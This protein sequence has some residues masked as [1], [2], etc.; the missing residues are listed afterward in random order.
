MQARAA[1]SVP[2]RMDAGRRDELSRWAALMAASADAETARA[3]RVVQAL[4]EANAAGRAVERH[5]FMRLADQLAGAR[6]AELRSAGRAI[7]TLCAENAALDASTG[8]RRGLPARARLSKRGMLIAV[9]AF[10]TQCT[11][12]P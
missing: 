1:A 9:A 5:E 3:G 2:I 7:S 4:C 8:R 10:W 6:S 12:R 11:Y